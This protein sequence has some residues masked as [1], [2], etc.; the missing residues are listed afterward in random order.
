LG[1]DPR[2][3]ADGHFLDDSL[4]MSPVIQAIDHL[5]FSFS[6]VNVSDIRYESSPSC[7]RGPYI[8]PSC[9]WRC[10]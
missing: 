3:V 9:S 1:T 10:N 5:R 6:L 8:P 2:R 7:A 4:D